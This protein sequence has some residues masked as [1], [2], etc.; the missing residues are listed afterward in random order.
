MSYSDPMELGLD[1]GRDIKDIANPDAIFKAMRTNPIIYHIVMLWQ[2][3]RCTWEQAMML[4]VVHLHKHNEELK[5]MAV[6]QIMRK[7]DL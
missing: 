4:A 6:D 7:V 2:H 1:E 5:K 3:G